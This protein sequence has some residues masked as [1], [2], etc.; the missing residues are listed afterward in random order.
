M[1][2]SLLPDFSLTQYELFDAHEFLNLLY[3]FLWYSFHLKIFAYAKM[4]KKMLD[5]LNQKLHPLA[6]PFK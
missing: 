3:L 4:T 5:G 1:V 2:F 6:F